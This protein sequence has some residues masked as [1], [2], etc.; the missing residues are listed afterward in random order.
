MATSTMQT[1]KLSEATRRS[2]A[3]LGRAVDTVPAHA[4]PIEVRLPEGAHPVDENEVLVVVLGRHE[5]LVSRKKV[6]GRSVDFRELRLRL[7]G[8]EAAVESLA[9]ARPSA[10]APQLTRGEAVLLDEAGLTEEKTDAPSALERSRIELEVLLS[11]S[12]SLD[13]AAK[14]LGVS[15]AR[16]RQRLS[17]KERTLYGIK[18]GRVWRL[19]RFQF[20]RSGKLV[21]GIA[22]VLPHVR[23]DAH[24]LAVKTWFSSPHQDL[25][26]GENEEP[27]TPLAWLSAGR[28]AKDVAMLAEEI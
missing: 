13:D 28:P 20:E 3:A 25:V 10:D 23:S 24:V 16:L 8:A 11:E 4:E 14:F 22:T 15:P 21:R 18:D 17:R 19:P 6:R 26:V 1:L 7:A 12:L 27:V 9:A 5:A 2:L